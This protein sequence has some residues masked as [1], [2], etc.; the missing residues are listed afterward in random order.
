MPGS[1]VVPP[2]M[3][4]PEA[5]RSSQPRREISAL[6]KEKISSILGCTMSR[7][8]VWRDSTR[9]LGVADL[10]MHVVLPELDGRVLAGAIAFKDTLPPHDGLA[11][12]ALTNRPELGSHQALVQATIGADRDGALDDDQLL[13]GHRGGDGIPD[14]EDAAQV[15]GRI[16]YA[17]NDAASLS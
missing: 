11:F 12:T 8:S 5:S 9:G 6:T 3:T 17:T 15:R 4:A 2:V 7:Q 1:C 14:G 13:F 10:A 16:R